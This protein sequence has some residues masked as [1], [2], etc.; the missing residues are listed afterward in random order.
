MAP[1]IA[2]SGWSIQ[3]STGSIASR[4]NR[5]GTLTSAA[6]HRP[7]RVARRTWALSFAPKAWDASGATAVTSPIPVTDH[8]KS[9]V[10]PSAAPASASLPSRP[11]IRTSTVVMTIWLSCIR[12]SG[13]ARWIV[14]RISRFQMVPNRVS[15]RV[16]VKVRRFPFGTCRRTGRYGSARGRPSRSGSGWL[17]CYDPVVIARRHRTKCFR[18]PIC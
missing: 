1:R 14:C 11:I 13:A 9:S 7:W 4:A 2:M 6:T 15:C 12:A 5:P 18:P 17:L 16:A 10:P 3:R 8:R